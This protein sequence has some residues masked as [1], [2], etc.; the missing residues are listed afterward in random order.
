VSEVLSPALVEALRQLDSCVISNAIETFDV[1]LRN[2]GF[3]DAGIRCVYPELPPVVGY[4]VTATIRC[5]T[6]PAVGHVY[7]DRTDWWT[8]ILRTPGPRIVVVQDVDDHPGLGAFVGEVHANILRALGCVAYVTNGAV[9]DLPA[10][11]T[12][13]LQLFAARTSPSHAFVHMVSFG[14]P[15]E[16]AGL[17]VAPGDVLFGDCHGVLSIPSAVASAVPA[18]AAHMRQQE[19]RVIE[20]CRSGDFSLEHLRSIVND[21]D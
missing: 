4:A 14:E 19:R 12:S 5:S 3:T 17:S 7:A 16:V 18:V 6:P 8:D 11:K 21:W 20:Y 10:V 9:R 1:R 15:V 13:G 2:E